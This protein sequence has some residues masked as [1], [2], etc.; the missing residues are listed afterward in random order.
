MT[1]VERIEKALRGEKSDRAPVI[2]EIIQH[3][4]QVSGICH[5]LYSTDGEAMARA[6]IV[7]QRVYGYDAVYIS[8][9]NYILAEALGGEIMFASDDVPPQITKHPLAGDPGNELMPFDLKNGRIQVILD[10]TRRC[11]AYYGDN[12]IYIKTCIDS[13]PFS[14]AAC[15]CGPENWMVSL[16]DEEEDAVRLLEKCTDIAIEMG[17]AAADAGAHAIAFGDSAAG[18]ISREMY[19]RFALPFAQ[20]AI[21]TIQKKT[22]CPV[23]YHICGN[24]DHILDLMAETGADCLELDSMVNLRK[25][26]KVV[27]GRCAI[28]GNVSTVEAFLNGTRDSVRKEADALLEHFGN[29]GGFIL[30]SACE[31]PRYSPVENVQELVRAAVE[32]PYED[33]ADDKEEDIHG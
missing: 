11:R 1:S 8:S 16:F 25:A 12:N 9:D 33:K 19:G 21:K 29:R 13:A 26:Q 2:P 6:Q 24:A 3:S 4:M 28:E 7:C 32:F 30:G 5:K 18:L 10:A 20:R 17:V 14:L 31:V 27:A 23:Y 22:G 15:L